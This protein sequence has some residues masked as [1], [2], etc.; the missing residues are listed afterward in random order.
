MYYAYRLPIVNGNWIYLYA[1]SR[2]LIV[3]K[4]R[5]RDQAEFIVLKQ[6]NW[7]CRVYKSPSVVIHRVLYVELSRG[8]GEART[9][10]QQSGWVKYVF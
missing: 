8:I 2:F 4:L 1:E 3:I 6:E 10:P 5:L 7:S 9:E